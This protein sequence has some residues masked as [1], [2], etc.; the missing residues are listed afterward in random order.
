[1]KSMKAHLQLL[2]G[3]LA[4]LKTKTDGRRAGLVR[5]KVLSTFGPIKFSLISENGEYWEIPE[6]NSMHA[7]NRIFCCIGLMWWTGFCAQ[8]RNNLFYTLVV[9]FKSIE[10]RYSGYLG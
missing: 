10:H 8:G 4:T 9:F 6:V 7:G 5:I 1:M 2:T 3:R